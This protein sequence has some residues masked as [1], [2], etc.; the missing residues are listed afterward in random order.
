MN[1]F[2]NHFISYG[3]EKLSVFTRATSPLIPAVSRIDLADYLRL[4]DAGDPFLQALVTSATQYVINRLRLEIVGRQRVVIYPNYPTIGRT[5][6][7]SLSASRKMMKREIELPYANIMSVQSVEL[8]GNAIAVDE[9]QIKK[10]LPASIEL[11]YITI[12]NDDVDAIKVEYTAGFGA[13]AD[14]VPEDLKFAVIMFAGY[15]YE[16]RGCGMADAFMQS[17]AC[18]MTMHYSQNLAVF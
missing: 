5:N 18:E 2:E 15:L 9:Y 13:T 17:G 10:T 3:D 11:D 14:D 4:D 1:R 8:Y 12:T 16:H 6:V 7:H